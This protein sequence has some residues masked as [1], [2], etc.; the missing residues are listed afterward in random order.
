AKLKKS[1][2]D[3]QPRRDV[4]DAGRIMS[5]KTFP[6]I[7]PSILILLGFCAVASGC[8][9]DPDPSFCDQLDRAC[10]FEHDDRAK[11]LCDHLTTL[12]DLEHP[13]CGDARDEMLRCMAGFEMVC[14]EPATVFAGATASA[15]HI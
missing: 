14:P 10:G 6:A 7:H 2:G 5:F 4:V 13:A 9:E 3:E 1:T 12:E 11:I 8:G 15:G